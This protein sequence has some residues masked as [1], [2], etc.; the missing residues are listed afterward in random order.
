MEAK[1]LKFL[2][3]LLDFPNYRAPLSKI[4]PTTGMRAPER[5]S[6]CKKLRARNL[7]DCT[8]EVTKLKITST[9]KALLKL[10][11]GEVPAGEAEIKVLKACAKSAITPDKT[12]I[13]ASEVQ[14]V[15]QGLEVRGLIK[16]LDK[17]ITEVSLT[18]RA[19]E[20]LRDEFES[21]ST[22]ANI[23]LKM[24]TDYLRFMR[25]FQSTKST[26]ALNEHAPATTNKPTDEEIL[27]IIRDLDYE[28]GKENFLPIFYL[29]QKLQP[30]L[31]REELDNALYRLQRENKIELS[32]LV[33]STPY[34]QEQIE[35]GIPQNIGG[36]LFFIILN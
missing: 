2:L 14:T 21:E 33:D 12:G 16:A 18:N 17:K 30:P 13:A 11:P 19:K 34:S 22:A 23:N 5:N 27:Q 29:R 36:P 7:V 4:K 26:E 24:L 35:A 10:A 25:K 6:I 15:I 1:E 32:S 31:S 9:G 3:K 20:F 8:E 28:M